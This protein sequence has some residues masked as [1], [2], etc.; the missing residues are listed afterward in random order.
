MQQNEW[1]DWAGGDAPLLDD[2]KV[3]VRLRDGSTMIQPVGRLRWDHAPA[4]HRVYDRRMDIV[5][6]RSLEPVSADGKGIVSKAEALGFPPG[7]DIPESE[8]A[9]DR[10]HIEAVMKN[11]NPKDGI[12]AMKVPLHLVSGIAKAY[13]A[14][15]H[16]LGNVKYGA[17]NFR[18]C[19]ARASVYKAALERHVDRWWEG[20][21]YDPVDGT[22]HLANALACLNILI[23][24][25]HSNNLV[26]DR[27][28]SRDISAVYAEFEAL[29]PKIVERYKDKAPRHYTIADTE[30]QA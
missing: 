16:F 30:L 7:Y 26:D 10:Q 20:E 29:M 19:G 25:K 11:T 9:L 12:G 4:G 17:W 28:P 23:E 21:E 13:Q 24:A 14:I 8:K 27:P 22:P 2:T 6:Y 3:E 18:V 5:A 1:N 15:A